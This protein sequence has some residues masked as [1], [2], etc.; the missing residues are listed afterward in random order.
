[1]EKYIPTGNEFISLP[2]INQESSGI[3]DLTILSMQHKGLL[4]IRGSAEVPLFQPFF[5]KQSKD[6]AYEEI[7]LSDTSWSRSNYWIPE[8]HFEKDGL[9]LGMSILT[10]IKE[11]G[12]A[13]KLYM[14]SEKDECVKLGLKGC[15]DSVWHCINED[16]QIDGTFYCYNSGW[17][18]SF[19]IDFRVGTALFSL[20]PMTDSVSESSFDLKDNKVTY[21]ISSNRTLSAHQRQE[22]IIFWGCGYEEVAAATSAKEMLRRGFDWEWNHTVNWLTKRT[23]QFSSPVL[24]ELYNTNLFFCIF[25][26][27]GLTIDT[28]ETVC[29]TSRSTRYY[30]S[31]AYWDRDSLLWAFPAILDVDKKLAK[32]IL[33]YIYTRQRRNIGVHSRYIDG[34]ILEP[35]FELDELVSP[36]LALAS[37]VRESNDLNILE[38]REIMT[39]VTEILEKLDE[40]FDKELGLYETF[41]QPT[42]DEIVYPYITYNNALVW[43]AYCELAKLYPK[44]EAIYL[45]KADSVKNAI[46]NNCIKV[47]D[48]GRKFFAWS[49]DKNGHYDIYDEPPGSLQL[50]PHYG[51]CSMEDEIWRNTVSIIRSPQYQYSFSDAKFAE[52][53]CPHAPYPWVLS[54]CNSLLAGYEKQAIQELEIIEMDNKIACESVDPETGTCTTGAAF[55]T[56]AGF[57]CHSMK[58]GIK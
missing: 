34:T 4:D 33:M 15:L 39:G 7:T 45:N 40:V 29:V 5:A 9:K 57:L 21:Q 22:L 35:G 41:L 12:F 38:Y 48:N 37:Y 19:I 49:I 55:A 42:D 53:G 23:Q 11:R 51:F 54:I 8:M 25:F 16:K 3:E 10:P 6:G 47:D 32:E 56:C 46:Y 28:E 13:I 43:K 1:M 44:D 20:A 17:N 31:A 52:I 18:D 30:V 14:E 24:T 50:L 36:I 26:A 2:K 58:L 27:T